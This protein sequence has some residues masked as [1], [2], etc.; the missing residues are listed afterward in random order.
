MVK[1]SGDLATIYIYQ[2]I[3]FSCFIKDGSVE[4]DKKHVYL[5]LKNLICPLVSKTS[6]RDGG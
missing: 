1:G 4:E 2:Y 3:F 6:N 5:I